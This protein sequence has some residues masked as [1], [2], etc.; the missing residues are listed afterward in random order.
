M[1]Q[2]YLENVIMKIVR[3]ALSLALIASG[4]LGV[5]IL[6]NDRWLWSAAPSHAYGL[7]VFVAIDLTL[8]LAAFIRV[9]LATLGAG[10]IATLQLGAMLGDAVVGQPQGVAASAFSM[11]LLS[12][13]SYVG[14]LAIQVGILFLAMGAAAA[15]FLH[16]HGR[17]VFFTHSQPR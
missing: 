7:I 5:E 4:L 10:L 13:T 1:T 17:T 14:L 8:A 6:A 9:S 3:D 16:K 11:Y 12:D 15:T 2:T